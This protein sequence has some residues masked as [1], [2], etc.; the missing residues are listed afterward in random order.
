MDKDDVGFQT[1]PYGIPQG[2]LPNNVLLI[3]YCSVRTYMHL[4]KL[5]SLPSARHAFVRF[6]EF[7]IDFDWFSKLRLDTFLFNEIVG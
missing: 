6:V 4:I 1:I 2:F 5:Q 7:N 3:Y